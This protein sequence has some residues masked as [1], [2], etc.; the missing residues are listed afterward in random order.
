MLERVQG[1]PWER[2]REWTWMRVLEQEEQAQTMKHRTAGH[3]RMWGMGQQDSWE[4]ASA[5]QMRAQARCRQ[6]GEA[7]HGK[8]GSDFDCRTRMSSGGAM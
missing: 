7:P 1:Q 2:V 8:R 3:Q 6:V 4:Q 5:E